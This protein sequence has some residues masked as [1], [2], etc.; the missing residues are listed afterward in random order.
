MINSKW[1]QRVLLPLGFLCLT[2]FVY[3]TF[4]SEP[5][6]EAAAERGRKAMYTVPQENVFAADQF[7]TA[8]EKD[9]GAGLR[10]Y[11]E[12]YVE[13]T[14]KVRSV[15]ADKGVIVLETPV[16]QYG[17][18]CSFQFKDD[19]TGVKPGDQV[20]IQGECGTRPKPGTAVPLLGSKLKKK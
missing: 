18:N 14:G 8:C 6:V 17:I 5:S 9:N 10:K 4:F 1:G 7:W 20:T 13:L 3:D 19:M 2:Y 16:P 11:S 15:N 12:Q